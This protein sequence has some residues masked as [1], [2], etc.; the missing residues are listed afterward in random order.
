MRPLAADTIVAG[1][2]GRLTTAACLNPRTRRP[3]RG[4]PLCMRIFGPVVDHCCLCRKYRGPQHAGRTC[5]KCGVQ[6][7]LARVRGERFG[8]LELVVPL[9]HPWL[10]ELPVHTLAVLPPLLRLLPPERD[11]PDRDPDRHTRDA[12]ASDERSGDGS[13]AD[14]PFPALPAVAGTTA[15]YAHLIAR[16][17]A[18]RAMLPRAPTVIVEHETQLLQAALGALFGPPELGRN[19]RGRRLRDLLLA[20]YARHLD[21]DD[22][23]ERA[24]LLR[25]AGLGTASASRPDPA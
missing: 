18:L 3:E 16:D 10:P 4:G 11:D 8:H 13:L 25:A 6:V 24:A 22:D 21:D 7:A 19:P 20:A 14:E 17:A 15:L 12:I 5:E 23:R 1:S 9:R 2:H